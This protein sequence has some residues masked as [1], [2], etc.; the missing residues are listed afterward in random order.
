[1]VMIGTFVSSIIL[2]QQNVANWIINWPTD[3]AS[4]IFSYWW[5][6]T[7]IQCNLWHLMHMTSLK[8]QTR[9][10][11]ILLNFYFYEILE[12][13]KTNIETNFQA[14]FFFSFCDSQYAWIS[15]LLRDVAFTWRPIAVMLVNKV[16]YLTDIFP[17]WFSCFRNSYPAKY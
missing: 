15:T 8:I 9:E 4:P 7:W 12:Q 13:L 11:S 14:E 10:L 6:V 3:T 16:W 2:I 17:V 5:N 1:M